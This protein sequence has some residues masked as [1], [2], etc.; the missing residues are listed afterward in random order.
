MPTFLH[1]AD[2]HLDSAFSA[3]FDARNAA[4]RRH[5][6]LRAVSQMA[7]IAKNL[8]IWLIAG[9]LFDGANVSAETV[10]F[11]KRTF[12]EMPDTKVFI[13]A[14]NHDVYSSNSVY[15]RE[16]LGENVHVFSTTGECVELED[17]K[18]R[19]FGI[20]FGQQNCDRLSTPKIEK[21][22]GYYDIML[23]HADLVSNGGESAYNPIDKSFIE[24]C[25]ADYLA[26]GH[27]HKRSE[28]Q[29][30][31]STV[32]AYSGSPEGRG[33][34]ECG[35]MGCYIGRACDGDTHVEFQSVCRRKMIITEVDLSDTEDNV[36]AVA[37]ARAAMT[38]QGGAEDIYRLILKGRVANGVINPEILK[39]ELLRDVHYVE[40]KDETE[41]DYN[42]EELALRK[43]LCG[44]FVRT[45]QKKIELAADDEKSVLIQALKLGAE[46]LL[47]GDRQ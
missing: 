10:A 3:R 14:G 34:D 1:T 23:L 37:L 40:I 36:G 33:F 11:L 25:G 27:I 42:F 22:D 29:R 26:L 44:E 39:E 32:Y 15:A 45:M 18:T 7:D 6:L 46:A 13:S 24:N 43:D 5:E 31:G 41:P 21:K 30:L 47:G 4:Q 8:D 28:P 17:I 12:A 2:I 38:S 16:N 19:V 20:S 9:D 35:D